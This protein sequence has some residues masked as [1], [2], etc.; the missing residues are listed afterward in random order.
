V[1][2]EKMQ[3]Q[4]T[5][6]KHADPC[7]VGFSRRNNTNADKITQQT[8]THK[9]SKTHIEFAIF[10]QCIAKVQMVFSSAEGIS[11]A[12]ADPTIFGVL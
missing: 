9:S 11:S 12:E 5:F 3:K 6:C 2:N 10:L 7:R 8:N 1:S 4:I